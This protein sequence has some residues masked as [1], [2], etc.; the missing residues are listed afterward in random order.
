RMRPF[1]LRRM[2]KLTF[3]SC[4]P[5]RSRS[6]KPSRRARVGNGPSPVEDGTVGGGD[7][8][9]IGRPSGAAYINPPVERPARG[10]TTALDRTSAPRRWTW[11]RLKRNYL[12]RRRIRAPG[13]QP[14]V[15]AVAQ[16][17]ED[18]LSADGT[19]DPRPTRKASRDP[20]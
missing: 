13:R 2:L 20:R 18:R 9:E 10:R 3:V 14:R 4:Q 5:M 12:R 7:H 19:H 11:N 1:S 16:G 8:M 15:R 17:P 6:K